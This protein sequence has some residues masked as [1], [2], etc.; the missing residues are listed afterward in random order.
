MI[1]RPTMVD[2]IDDIAQQ[3]RQG[4]MAAIIQ[5]LNEQLANSGVRTRAVIAEGALQLLCE[6]A[7]PE[8]LEASQLVPRIKEILE[9]IAPRNIRRV[10]IHSRIVR[11]QQL[12]WF[13]EINR[14]PENQ[15]LWSEKIILKK[16][17][18]FQ[19]IQQPESAKLRQRALSKEQNLPKVPV[20]SRTQKTPAWQG[21]VGGITLGML[22]ILIGFLVNDWYQL[23]RTSNTP[24]LTP[25]VSP[26]PAQSPVASPST[27]SFAEAVRLAEQAAVRG[28]EAQTRAEWL[29]IAAIWQRASD[30]MQEV[31][32]DDPRYSTA[33][34]RAILYSKNSEVTL[35]KAESQK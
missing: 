18:L 15:L 28:T 4:S 16:P 34:Q 12:L 23:R 8:E 35:F 21:W 6:A 11:E 13:D 22:L 20:G 17:N 9:A 7:T 29:D 10:H 27:D 33:Q 24:A 5:V 2:P 26:S 19:R 31:P 1:T 3:A 25:P 32:P 14:D 30:L